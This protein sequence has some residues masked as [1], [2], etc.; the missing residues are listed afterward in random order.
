MINLVLS[1]CT[2]LPLGIVTQGALKYI[3]NCNHT[4]TVQSDVDISNYQSET[5]TAV[6][7]QL[8]EKENSKV[9]SSALE[10]LL[11]T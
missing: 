9:Q 1:Q 10:T 2:I 11:G 4:P 6:R 7:Q 3:N 5:I 8:V